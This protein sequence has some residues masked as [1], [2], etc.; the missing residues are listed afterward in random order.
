[1][2][3]IWQW[4]LWNT[5][6]VQLSD[7]EH[8]PSQ[9]EALGSICSICQ[10]RTEVG[11]DVSSCGLSTG[12]GAGAHS[13]PPCWLVPWSELRRSLSVPVLWDPSFRLLVSTHFSGATKSHFRTKGPWVGLGLHT[14]VDLWR[15]EVWIHAKL[16]LGARQ[17]AK[18]S[19]GQ[20][21]FFFSPPL[22][23]SAGW[24][25]ASPSPLS[26]D[27]STSHCFLPFH[28]LG[29]L[30]QGCLPGCHANKVPMV[31]RRRCCIPIGSLSLFKEKG[32]R[33][34]LQGQ[35]NK[36]ISEKGQRGPSPRAVGGRM[37]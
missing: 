7:R 11:K 6:A 2:L 9:R 32:D 14:Q 25:A 30:S 18:G 37:L 13:L 1:M 22:L 15:S 3:F 31:T 23:S 28:P 29:C 24:K 19:A 21:F 26:Q 27:Y 16:L 5:L 12:E 35:T 17:R 34:C 20:F 8:L 36:Y 10:R 33:Y 4:R